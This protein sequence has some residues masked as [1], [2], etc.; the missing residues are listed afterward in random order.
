MTDFDQNLKLLPWV[1]GTLIITLC[2][3]EAGH[4]WAAWRLG[5]RDEERIR[6]R[7]TPLTFRHIHWLFTIIVPALMFLFV[8]F[9]MGG[10]RP[11]RVRMDLG[12]RKMALVALAGPMGNFLVAAV[13]LGVTAGLVHA[14]VVNAAVDPLVADSFYIAMLVSI[15]L[16]VFLGL[17]NLLPVP[18]L[19]GSRIVAALLPARWRQIYY[20]M[21]I[22]AIVLLFL[23]F[24]YLAIFHREDMTYFTDFCLESLHPWTKQV[25]DWI[26]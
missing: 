15:G 6:K 10:A 2:V 26:S 3:H 8:G 11:V 14:G 22:P 7:M 1:M 24:I 4:A 23:V 25:R 9:L 17:F 13:T 12:A 19:D 5:D 18:P 16:S 20:A 21:T